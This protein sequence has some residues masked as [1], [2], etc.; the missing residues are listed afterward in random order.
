MRVHYCPLPELLTTC[1]TYFNTEITGTL[2]DG[3]PLHETEIPGKNNMI[4]FGNESRGIS[5]QVRT[6]LTREVKIPVFDTGSESSESLN[7]GSAVAI[8]CWEMRRRGCFIR[9][10]N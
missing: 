6:L 8:M 4:V 9:N 1:H 7:I 5:H 10:E 3:Q 2:L